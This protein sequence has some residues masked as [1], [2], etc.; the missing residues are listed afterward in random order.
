MTADPEHPGTDI[1]IHG[2]AQSAGCMA[3]G[4][5]VAEEVYLAAADARNSANDPP[6]VHIFPCR[7]D[8]S[9]WRNLLV[10]LIAG[11]PELEKLWSS[12][13]AGY[14]SFERTRQL[15]VVR[16]DQRGSYQIE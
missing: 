4:D 8:D 13:R 1:F 3:I 16:V 10:P 2:D 5:A 7:M 12:L 9:N 11:R 6:A 15:P 14:D